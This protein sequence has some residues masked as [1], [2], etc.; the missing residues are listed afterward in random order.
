M[1]YSPMELAQA[2][3]KSGELSDALDALNRH[4]EQNPDDDEGLRLRSEVLSRFRDTVSLQKALNDLI[5]LHEP[6]FED[7]VRRVA[8]SQK[9]GDHRSTAYALKQALSLRP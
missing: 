6:A 7:W 8:L 2:F 4:L 9:L 1:V 5:Q 3:I